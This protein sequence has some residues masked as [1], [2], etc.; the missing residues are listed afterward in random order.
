MIR[1]LDALAIGTIVTGLVGCMTAGGHPDIP[2]A[3]ADVPGPEQGVPDNYREMVAAKIRDTFF[4]PYSIRDAEI[5]LPLHHPVTLMGKSNPLVC[6]RTNA[7]NR[8]GA[9]VGRKTSM[10]S[11]QHG[12]LVGS[13]SDRAVAGIACANAYYVPF[14]EIDAASSARETTGRQ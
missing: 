12:R 4:D 11:F 1:F 8:M 3:S 14:E 2:P 13:S 7:K 9:Y 10:Y 5:S 6:V